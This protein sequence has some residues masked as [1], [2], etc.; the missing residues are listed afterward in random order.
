MEVGGR[1]AAAPEDLRLVARDESILHRPS[2]PSL[3]RIL[4]DV[5][6]DALRRRDAAEAADARDVL[7]RHAERGAELDRLPGGLVGVVT[8]KYVAQC[9]LRPAIRA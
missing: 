4:D 2:G 6:R 1:A 8:V 3:L 7:D 9:G 5:E